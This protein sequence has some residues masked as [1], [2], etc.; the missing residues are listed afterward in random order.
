[1]SVNMAAF[2]AL[3]VV[4]TI[5]WGGT[6]VGKS[7]VLR[8]L[9]DALTKTWH[10]MIGATHLPEDFSGY[11]TPDKEEGVVR[12]M[13]CSY[14][15]K[16]EDGNG[17]LV[18]DEMTCVSPPV[19]A[20]EL[21]LITEGKVGDHYLPKSTIIVAAANPPDMAPGGTPL[22]ASMRSRFFHYQW[23]IDREALFAGFR[24]GLNWCAPSFPVVPSTYTELFPKYGGLVEA[25]LRANPD[26]LEKLPSS[27]EQLAF[28]NPRTWSYV[29]KTLAAA[30]A[31]DA[32]TPGVK[33][34]LVTGCV[35]DAS[36]GE[37]LRYMDTLDLVDP[38]AVLDGTV[39]FTY[40]TRTDLNICLLTGLVKELRVD[41]SGDRWST[42][43]EVFCQIGERE[44][45]TFL[46]QFRSL[47]TTAADGGVRPTGW[48]P[49]GALL[50]RLMGLVPS[51]ISEG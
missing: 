29:V 25:F 42:A 36:G 5:L 30:E 43:A 22:P 48:M 20:A 50:K 18:L 12:M 33:R 37:F 31:C 26:A 6:G 16:F 45:E 15:K 47:W 51:G 21:S 38:K 8:Q 14:V 10:L 49:S 13:P 41:A 39:K 46:T 23:Q 32:L 44:I 34:T 3:Q 2:I 35:G 7:S 27:D 19:L 17:F 24:K 11:P 28:P 4:P 9:N 1:M 40:S